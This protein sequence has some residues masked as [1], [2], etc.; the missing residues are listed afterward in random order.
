MKIKKYDEFV[1]EE[2]N[3]K[4]A[5]IGGALAASTLV[6]CDTEMSKR[7]GSD[8]HNDQTTVKTDIKPIELPNRFEMDEVF[9]TIGTDININSNGERIGK[10][11]ERTVSLGKKFEYFD[12]TDRKV[13]SAK[14][15]VFSWGTNIDVF[16]DKGQKI[17]SFEEEILES[18]FSIKSIYSIKDAS[19][20]LI[21]KSEKLEFLSTD[22][23]LLSPNG[24]L[25]CKIHR[26][27]INLFS[28]SWN[29]EISGNIDKRLVIFIPAYKTS[30]DNERRA[31][32]EE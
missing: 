19:G 17:G 5:I 24:D 27:A 14:E 2:I 30:A 29:I 1:N 11:E 7:Q 12:N 16:D 9:L 25:V 20:K 21:G 10:V 31:K 28:D 6:G 23:E 4:K 22:V 13:A 32:E 26:P 18:L 3:L 15:K 8:W